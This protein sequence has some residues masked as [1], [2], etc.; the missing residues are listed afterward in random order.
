M[1]SQLGRQDIVKAISEKTG[2]TK[3]VATAALEAVI[4]TITESLN[5]GVSVK[6]NGFG[7]FSVKRSAERT[8]YNIKTKE[9]YTLAAHDRLS[10]KFAKDL[11][12]HVSDN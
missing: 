11:K 5:A 3:A 9:T 7:V 10:F 2:V 6:F 1:S 12:R 8:C 4:S